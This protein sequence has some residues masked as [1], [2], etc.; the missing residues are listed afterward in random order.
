M[1][2]SYKRMKKTT[3]RLVLK[4]RQTVCGTAFCCTNDRDSVIHSFPLTHD[5]Y[6][7]PFWGCCSR[8]A[9]DINDNAP[10]CPCFSCCVCV[11]YVDTNEDV[12]G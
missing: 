12:D 1:S 8:V 9:I 3:R 5:G 6:V 4:E 10:R 11:E 7:F 2:N